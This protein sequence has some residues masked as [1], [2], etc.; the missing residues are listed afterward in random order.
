M[1]P[2][3]SNF[4]CFGLKKQLKDFK[5]NN[6]LK[7]LYE[8]KEKKVKDNAKEEYIHKTEENISQVLSIQQKK[9]YEKKINMLNKLK[10][11]K[12]KSAAIFKIKDKVVGGKKESQEAVAMKHPKTKK[13]IV[14][15]IK[16]KE[17]SLSVELFQ[18]VTW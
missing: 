15:P 12:G 1:S 3:E 14:D 9:E 7:L 16:L 11:E 2:K 13:L 8:E 5:E 17:A 10:H 18:N 4:N 6:Q